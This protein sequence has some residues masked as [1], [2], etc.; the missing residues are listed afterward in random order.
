LSPSGHDNKK[1]LDYMERD[2]II[3]VGNPNVG[4]S[5]IFGLLTGKYVTV[6]NY[7]GTTVE[8][9]RA[10]SRFGGKKKYLVIDTR[11]PTANSPVRRRKGYA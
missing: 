4:K 11:A 1:Q 7:P 5:V 6:S 3:L 8:V 2:K 10:F 9:S